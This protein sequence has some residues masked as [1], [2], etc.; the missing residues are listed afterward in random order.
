M[1]T[2]K[3]LKVVVKSK[4]KAVV[5]PSPQLATLQKK[6]LTLQDGL[7][8]LL[9]SSAEKAWALGRALNELKEA[10][11]H[12]QWEPWCRENL[13]FA[14]DT[15]YRF[16]RIGELE[17]LPPKRLESSLF[18]SDDDPLRLR[19]LD[20]IASIAKREGGDVEKATA[21]FIKNQASDRRSSG[22][23]G[24]PDM[25]R[26]EVADAVRRGKAARE[27]TGEA[28]TLRSSTA[29]MSRNDAL[30][31]FGID[32]VQQT[33]TPESLKILYRGLRA[34]RHSDKGG[35]DT[36]FVRLTKAEEILKS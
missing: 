11:P 5:A 17:R 7:G 18:E 23:P 36:A 24:R 6:V 4:S 29:P 35:N 3:K 1:A 31:E 9:M 21:Q 34:L 10:T 32:V 26:E 25:T 28:P 12:G 20:A 8:A 13:R 16:M 15:I 19:D 22:Q 2:K 27:A 33:I 14:R 30:L